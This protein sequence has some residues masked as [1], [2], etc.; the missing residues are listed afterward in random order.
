MLREK[1]GIGGGGRAYTVGVGAIRGAGVAILAV[2]A[3]AVPAVDGARAVLGAVAAP[4]CVK[5]Q[6]YV[7]V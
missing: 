4:L 3:Q 7:L 2:H 1:R 6:E 5:L